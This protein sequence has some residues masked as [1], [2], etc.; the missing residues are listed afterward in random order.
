MFVCLILIFLSAVLYK[1]DAQ[2]LFLFF[3]SVG[4]TGG[5]DLLLVKLRNIKL[6]VPSA[7]L[8]SGSIIG[9]LYN[10]K[11]FIYCFLV[12]VVLTVFSKHFIRVGRK[13][14]FN[15]AA[16]GLLLGSIIFSNDISWW[17]VSF[18]QP[19]VQNIFL[20]FSLL[21]L[22]LPG[23]ISG[24]KMRRYKTIISFYA[25]YY[26][27]S[28]FF[29]KN[30]ALFDPTVLFFSLVMLP[31]P[32]T[33][34]S[35]NVHQ[36]LFGSFVGVMSFLISFPASSFQLLFSRLIPDPLIGALLI[37]NLLFFRLR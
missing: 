15:P 11:L 16:F 27:M 37:G 13:H 6:F 2:Y 21:L 8:V 30:I 28:Y 36:I 5:L 3:V 29:T 31:E 20:L 14:I 33:S 26:V 10:P 18:Q 19:K 7:A 25:A 22:F 9:L 35:K 12:T 1:P 32:M 23:Y 24:L 17:A 4:L 34:P